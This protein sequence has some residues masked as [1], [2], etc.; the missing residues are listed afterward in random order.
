MEISN[1]LAKFGLS[2]REQ[3]VYL[4]LIKRSWSTALQLARVGNVKRTTLYRVLESLAKKG[5]VET[6][7]DD[8][9]TFYNAADPKQFESLIIQQESR[10][11]HLRKAYGDL[12]K[13]L[14]ILTQAISKKE[15]AVR[16]YRALKGLEY[17][18]WK[19]C[20]RPKIDICIFDS[21]DFWFEF[22]GREFA[23][24]IRAETV[25][26]KILIR[27]LGNPSTTYPVEKDGACSW[28]D[29]REYVLKHYVHRLVEKNELNITQDIYIVGGDFIHIH[30]YRDNDIFGV[31][32]VSRYFTT[33]MKQLFET[34]WNRAKVVDNF[35]GKNVKK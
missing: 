20:E 21:G 16:F 2:E 35:G 11:K 22:L 28:T 17:L 33:M 15:T 10:A 13:H 14:S 8:K 32:L 5:L 26:Q 19:R 23:E 31:E 6:Q 25:K 3:E 27:E 29:N 34:I 4:M 30:G 1:L 7:I 9:T 24:A 18:E 12:S